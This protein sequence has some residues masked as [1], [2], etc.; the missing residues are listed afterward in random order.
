MSKRRKTASRTVCLP[1]DDTLPLEFDG[2]FFRIEHTK[3]LTREW[4]HYLMTDCEMF[5]TFSELTKHDMMCTA[6][7]MSEF[8]MQTHPKLNTAARR[9]DVF[10]WLLLMSCMYVHNWIADMP[11]DTKTYATPL[12]KKIRTLAQEFFIFCDLVFNLPMSEMKTRDRVSGNKGDVFVGKII[13]MLPFRV[14]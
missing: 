5:D 1:E 6:Y 11:Y 8:I 9:D 13:K 4:L 7:A 10:T 3:L 12:Q 14:C 2:K